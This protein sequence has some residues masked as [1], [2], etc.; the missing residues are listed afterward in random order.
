MVLFREMPSECPGHGFDDDEAGK[1]RSALLKWYDESKRILPWRTLPETEKE[2][3][4]RGYGVWVSEVMLQQTQVATV[5]EYY[6]KWMRKW[7]NV[8]ALS[9]ADIEDVMAAWSGLGYYSRAKRLHEGAKKVQADFRGEM[10]KCS[11]RL[12]KDLPGVG[13]YTASAIAS[14]AFNEV[15]GVV[16]GNVARVLAR[17]RRIGIKIDSSVAQEFLWSSVDRLVDLKRPGDF[18]QAMME[19]GAVICTP[20]NPNCEKCPVASFC[21]AFDE[22]RGQFKDIEEADCRLCLPKAERGNEISVTIYPKKKKAAKPKNEM[23]LVCVVKRPD[24]NLLMLQRPEKGLLA[25]LLE[26]PS[27]TIKEGEKVPENS[28]QVKRLFADSIALTNLCFRGEVLHKFSHVHHRYRV[29]TATCGRNAKANFD[30]D[31]R[32]IDAKTMTEKD[33]AIS[34]AMRKVFNETV[35]KR[36]Q[37]T[38]QN[39]FAKKAKTEI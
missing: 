39:F 33:L 5:I 37:P 11:E 24:E 19:L 6:N 31:L 1:F 29:W 32:W 2:A 16:D 26:F 7:P 23:I 34:E 13:R 9:E 18:N 21:K 10:P 25:N 8:V 27:R 15:V 36:K 3:D 17:L 30:R 28:A 22:S 12:R 4:V 35:K 14:I 20:K 38:I